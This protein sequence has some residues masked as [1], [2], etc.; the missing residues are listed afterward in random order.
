MR[1][2]LLAGSTAF[3]LSSTPAIAQTP[4]RAP[5]TPPPPAATK[6]DPAPPAPPPPSPTQPDPAPPA[7]GPALD[8]TPSPTGA[9]PPPARDAAEPAPTPSAPSSSATLETAPASATQSRRARTERAGAEPS[10]R[11]KGARK[12]VPRAPNRAVSP[13]SGGGPKF[14]SVPESAP[15]PVTSESPLRLLLVLAGGLGLLAALLLGPTPLLA[16]PSFLSPSA[17]AVVRTLVSS[18]LVGALGVTVGLLVLV[19]VGGAFAK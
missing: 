15:P 6:A 10:E 16:R 14:D 2:L 11:R 17:H 9:L 1:S 19:L 7:R 8:R 13:S 3:L 5:P 18:A 4:D 12:A